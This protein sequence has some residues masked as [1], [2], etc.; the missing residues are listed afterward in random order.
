[1]IKIMRINDIGYTFI[2]HWVANTTA[3]DEECPRQSTSPACIE[4]WCQEAEE[5]LSNGNPALIEMSHHDTASGRTET[6]IVPE[7]GISTVLVDDE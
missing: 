6:F 7:E 5:S 2:K 1:M 4:H 3:Y